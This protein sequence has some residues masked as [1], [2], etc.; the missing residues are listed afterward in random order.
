VLIDFCRFVRSEAAAAP[1]PLPLLLLL[2][3][4][5]LPRLGSRNAGGGP[6]GPTRLLL[7]SDKRRLFLNWV[8]AHAENNPTNRMRREVGTCYLQSIARGE[9]KLPRIE[10]QKKRDEKGHF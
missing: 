6:D 8:W 9:G 4:P 2:P 3:P 7:A 1:L 10:A 5:P